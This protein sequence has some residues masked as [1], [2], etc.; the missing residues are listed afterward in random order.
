[1]PGLSEARVTEQLLALVDES[2]HQEQAGWSGWRR[3]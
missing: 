2:I 1:M 3:T